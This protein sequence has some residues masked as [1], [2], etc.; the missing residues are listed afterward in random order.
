MLKRSFLFGILL[1]FIV[2]CGD[3]DD[4]DPDVQLA[5]DIARIDQYV[6]A[7]GLTVQIDDSGI[8]YIINTEGNGSF[9]QS[10]K[11]VRVDFEVFL[12]DGTF[13]DTS[14]EQTARDNNAYNSD[15]TYAPFQFRIGGGGVIEGF[16]LGTRL[17][18]LG[19][20][21]TFLLPS[22]LA[23]K[24]TGSPSGSVPANTNLIFNI[25]LVEID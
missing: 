12:L 17:L 8:R 24:N 1:V 7:E 19:G 21:G 11:I 14:I 6:I 9:P 4:Y 3:S 22:T 16:D 5:K 10:G 15:R 18:S 25:A 20:F 2:G 23:Y 13:V